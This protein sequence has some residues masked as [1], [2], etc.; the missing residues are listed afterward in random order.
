MGAFNTLE[1]ILEFPVV[2]DILELWP[3]PSHDSDMIAKS[4]KEN[5][6]PLAPGTIIIQEEEKNSV[7]RSHKKSRTQSSN[8][9]HGRE[10]DPNVL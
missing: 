7:R 8:Y 10:M 5:L 1:V 3:I 6:S 9:P 2:R 4:G